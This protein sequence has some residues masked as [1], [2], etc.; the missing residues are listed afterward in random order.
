MNILYCSYTET[1]NY[2]SALQSNIFVPTITFAWKL[3]N[4]NACVPATDQSV[5]SN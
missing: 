2:I 3:I 5:V 4:K 1:S